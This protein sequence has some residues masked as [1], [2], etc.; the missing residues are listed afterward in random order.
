MQYEIR[1]IR[2]DELPQVIELEQT[3]F[4]PN[5]ACSPK[6]LSER[7]EAAPELFLGVE[8]RET[9]LLVGMLNGIAVNEEHFR[10]EFFTDIALHNPKGAQVML[11]GL[12]VLAEHRGR[13][14][15]RK[16]VETYAAIEQKRGRAKLVLTC[17]DEKVEMYRKMGFN[18]LG[19]AHSTWGGEEWHEMVRD[20]IPAS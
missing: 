13:G 17:L 2:P 6:H 14:L 11:C 7:Y 10:D 12:E 3:C 16:L 20:L 5:E 15:A 19:M 4:P 18:D 8:N 9:G 1:L